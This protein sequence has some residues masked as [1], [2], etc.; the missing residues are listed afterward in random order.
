MPFLSRKTA[1]LHFC[2]PSSLPSRITHRSTCTLSRTQH[3]TAQH[4]TL[5]GVNLR[6]F[7]AGCEWLNPVKYGLVSTTE[8]AVVATIAPLGCT[9]V[10]SRR[11]HRWSLLA[12]FCEYSNCC[13]TTPAL[14]RQRV[15]L[16]FKG[17]PL[18]S[19]SGTVQLSS[20]FSPSVSHSSVVYL[21]PS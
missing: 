9:S 18:F 13:T 21:Q 2:P 1:L 20:P 10:T 14:P 3:S 11:G 19:S 12:I 7:Q 17:Y 8:A 6:H 4:R 5:C 16:I 15:T